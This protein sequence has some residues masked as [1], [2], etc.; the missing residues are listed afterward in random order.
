MDQQVDATSNDASQPLSLKSA[1][2]CELL[3]EW[4]E[5]P[6]ARHGSPPKVLVDGRPVGEVDHRIQLVSGT[7]RVSVQTGWLTSNEWRQEFQPNRIVILDYSAT[8]L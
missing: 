5:G 8:R 6:D 4:L 1:G 3:V 2:R 7:H